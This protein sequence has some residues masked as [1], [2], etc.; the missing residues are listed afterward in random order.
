MQIIDTFCCF[1]KCELAPSF[2]LNEPFCDK[3]LMRIY[4]SVVAFSESIDPDA[5]AVP[6]VPRRY[7]RISDTTTRHRKHSIAGTVYFVRYQDRIKIGFTTNLDQ[8][9][10]EIPCDEVLATIPGSYRVEARLHCQ[11]THLH[12]NGE[13]FSMG[14]DLM[15]YIEGLKKTA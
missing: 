12:L 9:V 5:V 7:I 6:G 3:H 14:D 10:K 1:P 11:F 4:R 8:R 13:W 2:K 15:E